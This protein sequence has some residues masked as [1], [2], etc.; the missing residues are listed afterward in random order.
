MKKQSNESIASNLSFS[1]IQNNI[2]DD[3]FHEESQ[4]KQ[5]IL[6]NNHTHQQN[7]AKK[8]VLKGLLR[9]RSWPNPFVQG[10]YVDHHHTAVTLIFFFLSEIKLKMQMLIKSS[11]FS[12]V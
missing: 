12:M 9:P 1:S 4:P 2:F 3:N 11:V 7:S 6:N 8:R 5:M 10:Q